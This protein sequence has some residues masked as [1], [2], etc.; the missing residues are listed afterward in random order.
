[1]LVENVCLIPPPPRQGRNAGVFQHIPSLRNGTSGGG[2]V[3]TVHAP[4]LRECRC[5]SAYSVSAER[6]IRGRICRDG[7]CTVSTG[8]EIEPL[9]AIYFACLK[10][11][12]YQTMNKQ[13][14]TFQIVA[15]L[16]RTAKRWAETDYEIHQ[17]TYNYHLHNDQTDLDV[18]FRKT[19]WFDRIA[20]SIVVKTCK[21]CVI[22]VLSVYK[23]H[24]IFITQKMLSKKFCCPNHIILRILQ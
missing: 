18:F 6:Y 17:K 8:H 23:L 16:V 19:V 7:A 10:N 12:N 21:I 22:C 13:A 24:N 5:F 15:S 1:M 3:E 9:H 2:S 14:G 4:S 11:E 20:N